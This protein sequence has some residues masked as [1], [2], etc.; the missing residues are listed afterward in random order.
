MTSY[1][2]R[3]MTSYM[4]YGFLDDM[5]YASYM[6]YGLLYGMVYDFVHGMVC[7]NL[8]HLRQFPPGF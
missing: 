5:V 2:I 8:E 4:V 3:Y 1:M 6:I 7:R